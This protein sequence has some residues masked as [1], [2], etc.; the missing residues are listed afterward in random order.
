MYSWFSKNDSFIEKDFIKV[1]KITESPDEDKA[2]IL[3]SLNQF[4]KNSWINKIVL[5]NKSYW[6]LN[7]PFSSFEQTV[8]M[9]ARTALI[10]AETIN[11]FCD[12][13]GIEKEKCDPTSLTEKDLRNLVGICLNL[14]DKK[15]EK[16]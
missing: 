3:A 8:S 11:N 4:E 16:D 2:A 6:I 5:N 10:I 15:D 9:E 1:L 13:L 14:A 12:S 7:R